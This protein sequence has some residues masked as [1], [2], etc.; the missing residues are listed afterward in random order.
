MLGQKKQGKPKGLGKKSDPGGKAT[1]RGDKGLAHGAPPRPGGPQNSA[2]GK[3]RCSYCG[4]PGHDEAQCRKKAA[5]DG[6]GGGS[7]DQNAKK[8]RISALEAAVEQFKEVLEA[9]K[10]EEEDVGSITLSAIEIELNAIMSSLGAIRVGIDSGAE[11][12][13]WPTSLHPEVETEETWESKQGVAHWAPG[14]KKKPTIA[15]RGVGRY[16]LKAGSE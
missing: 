14:D 9:F 16:R 2:S 11:L 5:D 3:K 10:A 4:V 15:D 7:P 1:G 8:R 6:S 12:S 13:V